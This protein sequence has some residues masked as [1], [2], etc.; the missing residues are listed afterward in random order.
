MGSG[1]EWVGQPGRQ[2]PPRPVRRRELPIR[3]LDVVDE[4][5]QVDQAGVEGV[6][7]LGQCA[8]GGALWLF[9]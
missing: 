4:P 1:S 6:E 8:D 5:D 9:S 7:E 3:L 2:A